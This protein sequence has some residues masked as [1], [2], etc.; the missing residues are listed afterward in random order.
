[1]FTLFRVMSGSPSDDEQHAIDTLMEF[2]PMMKFVFVFFMVTSSW[3][4]LSILTAVVSENMISTTG[5]QEEEMRLRTFEE[6]RA[7]KAKRLMDV[8]SA[9]D[10][11]GDGKIDKEELC[12][13]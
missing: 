7:R 1:M 12:H 11:S 5:Q 4:L 8:F 2:L 3:T 9:I 13:F 10:W 6:E